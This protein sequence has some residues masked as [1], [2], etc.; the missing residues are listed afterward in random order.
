MYGNSS[1]EN[2]EIPEVPMMPVGRSGKATSHTPDVDVSGKSDGRVVPAKDPNKG[3]V[4]SSSEG[5]EGSRPTKENT[6]QQTPVPGTAPDMGGSSRLPRVREVARQDKRKRFTTLLHHVTVA[7]LKASFFALKREASPGVDGVTWQAYATDLNA[8]LEKLHDRVHRGTYRAQ[9][10]KR[11]YIAKA[12]GRLRPLGMAAL[13]DKIVQHAV[14][15]VLN[16]IYEVDFVG[17]SYGFRSKR[18]QHQALDALWVGLMRKR[19]NW[20]LDADIRGFFDTID[21]EWLMKFVEH[22]IADR[23]GRLTALGEYLLA[24]RLRSL[25]R[26][27]ATASG[28]RRRD[29]RP[30]RG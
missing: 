4:T 15:T 22:R 21:H 24:L 13:E 28:D 20:V 6:Q 11:A 18:N 9:P 30:V 3:D 17:F 16:A 27:L 23:R 7:L 26:A 25:G 1:R 5:P 12:D 10:L 29:C 14:V 19:V 2:R 8:R